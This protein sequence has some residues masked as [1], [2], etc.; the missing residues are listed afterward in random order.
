MGGNRSLAAAK[1]VAMAG[2]LV[3]LSSTYYLR[4]EVLALNQIRFAADQARAENR[5]KEL[6]ESFPEAVDRYQVQVANYELQKEHY[7]EMLA[8]Y[9]TDYEEYARRIKEKYQ[10]PQLPAEPSKPVQPEVSRKLHELNA[11]FIARKHQYFQAS[12]TLNGIAWVAAIAL[13]GGLLYLLFFDMTGNRWIYLVAL[14]LSFVFMIGP[15]F[16]SI[17]T[18]IIGFLEPPSIYY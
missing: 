11:E 12:T 18:A 8:L 2:F 3:L 10:P 9:R 15:S 4:R 5:L 14:S 16:H 17:M 6:A 13:V 7:E 1:L